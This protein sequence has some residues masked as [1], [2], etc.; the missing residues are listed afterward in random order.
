MSHPP[1]IIRAS[2]IEGWSDTA[3]V[4]V[5]G[6]GIAGACAALE[7]RRAGA[8]VL[9]IERAGDGGGASALSS[10]IFYLGGGTAVQKAADYEDTPEAMYDFLMANG[11]SPDAEIVRAFC[12]NCVA[13]FDWLEAQG[14]DAVIAQGLEA[15]GHRG[16]FLNPDL[17]KQLGTFALLPQIVQAV[18][19]FPAPVAN[20][21]SAF[22][23]PSL[24]DF[25]RFLIAWY[26]QS[27][28][29]LGE[30]YGR[31]SK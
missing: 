24:K 14:V 27:R 28:R 10:G 6:M 7:A 4:I 26:W 23:F 31:P 30:R 18:N 8:D 22:S 19:V 12:D 2:S 20:T 16:H 15:G 11:I 5:V 25:S 29:R 17:T 3:D 9:V 21:I 13:H 1:E